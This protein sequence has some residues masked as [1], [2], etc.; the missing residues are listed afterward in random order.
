[1]HDGGFCLLATAADYLLCLIT[2]THWHN[3]GKSQTAGLFRVS[4]FTAKH[5]RLFV[6]DEFASERDCSTAT[7]R[8]NGDIFMK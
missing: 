8:D 3:L 7:A 1:M 6:R 2:G 4:C 5:L